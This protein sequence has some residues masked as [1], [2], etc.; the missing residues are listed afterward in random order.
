MV[1]L[2]SPST[3]RPN[4]DS[5]LMLGH[6]EFSN[7]GDQRWPKY[8]WS[9]DVF[10][11]AWPA[12]R[13]EVRIGVHRGHCRHDPRSSGEWR[14]WWGAE[15]HRE[16][17]FQIPCSKFFEIR[18]THE[19]P[20]FVDDFPWK[21][22]MFIDFPHLMSLQQGSLMTHTYLGLSTIMS[23]RSMFGLAEVFGLR[24]SVGSDID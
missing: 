7:F 9:W 18:E 1:F 16:T 5:C 19:D 10:F 8:T 3:P 17:R 21:L 6:M 14:G 4:Q 24:L 12:A 15:R 11:F 13:P 2:L 23:D 22:W 20:A